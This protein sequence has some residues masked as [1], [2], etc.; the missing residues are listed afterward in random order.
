MRAMS[1]GHSFWHPIGDEAITK[2]ELTMF[3]FAKTARIKIS[4]RFEHRGSKRG[5]RVWRI[6]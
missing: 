5:I 3:G 4:T 1:V 2:A 6:A